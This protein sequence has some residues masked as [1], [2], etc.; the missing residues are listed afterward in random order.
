MGSAV[1]LLTSGMLSAGQVNLEGL[2]LSALGGELAK[3]EV[4]APAAPK[5]VIMAPGKPAG[6]TSEKGGIGARSGLV[7]PERSFEGTNTCYQKA[8]QYV[9]P[10]PSAAKL[11]QGAADTAPVDCYAG[12]Y[13]EPGVGASVAFSICIHAPAENP[14]G[15]LA[16]FQSLKP[17]LGDSTAALL[18][19]GSSDAGETLACYTRMMAENANPGD[20]A[21]L[22]SR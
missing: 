18:C 3:I 11:C 19:R 17:S 8:L 4:T 5:A 10:P 9:S 7:A 6:G 2:G 14:S 13:Q 16:C 12:A 15:P 20:A 21:V 22:C 1:F